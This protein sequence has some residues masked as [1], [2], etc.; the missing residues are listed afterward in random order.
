[1]CKL[2]IAGEGDSKAIEAAI[3]KATSR[4][5][6]PN[7]PEETDEEELGSDD[8]SE[9]AVETGNNDG[10]SFPDYGEGDGTGNLL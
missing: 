2:L 9:G 1:M 8:E 5:Q 6:P 10:D 3:E 4:E 7:G